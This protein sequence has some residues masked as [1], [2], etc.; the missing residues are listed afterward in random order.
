MTL[1]HCKHV[2]IVVLVVSKKAGVLRSPSSDAPLMMT[3][4]HM[5]N[6]ERGPPRQRANVHAA[7]HGA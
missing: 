3:C 2:H 1:R 7:F 6:T 4:E 5:E